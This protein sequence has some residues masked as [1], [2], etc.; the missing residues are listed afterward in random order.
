MRAT[1]GADLIAVGH[2]ERGGVGVRT[3]SPERLHDS[4]DLLPRAAVDDDPRA[5]VRQS[6][7]Q[8]QADAG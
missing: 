2:V 8:R 3:V 1:R 5:G 7:R 6:A 4:L